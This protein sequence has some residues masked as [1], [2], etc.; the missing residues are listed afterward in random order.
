[1]KLQQGTHHGLLAMKY[2]VE[3][4]DSPTTT[5]HIGG[6]DMPLTSTLNTSAVEI[7]FFLVGVGSM[8]D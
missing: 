1:M 7:H 4:L 6:C 2:V 5:L 8:T 3:S